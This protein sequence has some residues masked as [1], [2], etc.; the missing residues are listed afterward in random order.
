M[1]STRA[2]IITRRTY[3]RPLNKEGTK[4]ETWEQTIGRVISH[5]K[6]LWE[7]AKG[8]T[9]LT[10]DEWNELAEL[11][12]LLIDRKAAVAGR[13]LW[14]GDTEISR[15]RES[16][17]FNC[18]FTVVETVYDVV[19]VLW[20]LLQGCGVGFKPITGTLN[21]FYKPIENIKVTH[22]TRDSKGGREDNLETWD[23]DTKIWTISVGD[24]A[25]SW[26]RSIG[27]LLAGKYPAKELH[28]DFS[29]IRPSGERLKGYGWISSGS[30][31][32]GRAYYE[33]AQILNLRSGNLLRKMDILDIVNWLGT[34]LSSRRSAELA[35]FD[36]G[37]PEWQDFAV[38]KKD[39]WVTGNEQRQQSNNSLL[40]RY[41]PNKKELED[42]FQLMADSG[43]SEPG[44]I[45]GVAALERAPWFKGVNPCAEILLGNKTFCNLT[46]ID[47]GKFVGDQ[48][49]LIRCL[50]L[51][52]RANYRQNL[53]RFTRWNLTRILAS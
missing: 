26:A 47:L 20:L 23:P 42:I 46:E 39:W 37:E 15:R 14:L 45:N 11:Q 48:A 18:S 3:N 52:A 8:E 38:A 27:K 10:A 40:F 32:I 1:A 21:G 49:G 2:E 13:T 24:S 34:V 7:R 5:Q 36:Y 41:R 53:C 28:L 29:Q 25:E 19:D 9:R 4:F 33:I 30:E 17:M 16:S 6:W 44:F 50:K 12:Q 31:A 22:T 35:L 43:G 51:I